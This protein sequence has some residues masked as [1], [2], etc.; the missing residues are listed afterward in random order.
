MASEPR[1]FQRIEL[2]VIH[3]GG[4]LGLTTEKMI[5]KTTNTRMTQTITAAV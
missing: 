4:V 5:P 2:G 3:Q 1:A